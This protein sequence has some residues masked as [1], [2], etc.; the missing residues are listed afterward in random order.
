MEKQLSSTE[1]TY[2]TDKVLAPGVVV[3][4]NPI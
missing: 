3:E 2:F 4:M 1:G